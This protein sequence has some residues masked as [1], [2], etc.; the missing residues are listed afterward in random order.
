[1][2]LLKPLHKLTP[3]FLAILS[4]NEIYLK[5]LTLLSILSLLSAAIWVYGPHLAWGNFTP[6][7]QPEKR[8]YVIAC[9]FLIWVL[10][11]LIIDMDLPNP[12]QFKDSFIQK[13][14]LACQ[15]R[16]RGAMQF[17][18]KTTVSKNGKFVRLSQLPW[19]LLIGPAESGKTS[20]LAQSN[21]HFILQRQFPQTKPLIEPSEHC[22]WW[23]TRD[24]AIIDVPGKY[25][26]SI[27]VAPNGQK[28]ASY[29]VLWKFFLQLIKR[30]RGKQGIN[31]LIIALPLPELM[32]EADPKKYQLLIDSFFQR[33]N[34][35]HQLFPHH[36]PF[37]LLI[38]KCDL[39]TGFNE[40]FSELGTDEAA[41]A[42][43]ITL[44]DVAGSE[45]MYQAFTQRFNILIK[46]LNEQL[47]MRLH[48]ERNAA[49]R[50][51][52]KDFP[53]EVERLKESSLE[54]IKKLIA[55]CKGLQLQGVYLSSSTQLQPESQETA[56]ISPSQAMQGNIQLF[57]APELINR[58]YFIKQFLT[59]SLSGLKMDDSR[60][61]WKRRAAYVTSASA[62]ALTAIML[63]RDFQQ[64]IKHVY[65]IQHYITEYQLAAQQFQT[66]EER[67]TRTLA[68][69]D[70]LHQSSKQPEFKLDLSHFLSFYS[71]KSQETTNLIYLQT[72]Q[73]IL[74]PEIKSY[75]EEYLRVPINK[76]TDSI[77]TALKAYLMLGDPN[78]F[79]ARFVTNTVRSILPKTINDE[80]ANHLSRHLM[81]A[82]NTKQKPQALNPE[83]IKKTREFLMTTPSLSLSYM[84]LKNINN[85]NIESG[86]NLGVNNQN[87]VFI[88]LQNM[89]D[90]P[91][92]FTAKGF[93]SIFSQELA[94]AAQESIRGNWVL[95]LLNQSENNPAAIQTL[96][97]Q[98]RTAYVN[99][100]VDVWET[101]LANIQLTPAADLEKL[102]ATIIQIIGNTSPLL[103]LLQ[104]LRNNTFFQPIAA[105]SPRLQTLCV[106]L[107]KNKQSQQQ[108][109]QIFAGLN[110]LHQQLRSV[111]TASNPRKAAFDIVSKRM[112][113]TSPDAI[114]QLRLIAE[115]N[116]EP[117]KN[118]LNKIA[119]D[120]WHL[121]TEEAGN[122]LNTA[123]QTDVLRFYQADIANRYPFTSSNPQDVDLKKFTA[124]FGNPGVMVGFYNQYLHFL[125]DTSHPDWHWK[126][127][128]NDKFPLSN[129]TLHQIQQAMRIHHT[130]FPNG[131]NKLYMQFALEPHQF[132]KNVKS[133]KLMVSD[134]QII[135]EKTKVDAPHVFTWPGKNNIGTSV[136]FTLFDQKVIDRQFPGEWGW[137]KLVSQSFESAVTKKQLLIN[138]S[139]NEVPVK[140]YVFTEG[141]ANPFL[142]IDL[143]RFHLPEKMTEK[144]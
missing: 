120:T 49:A 41:Q 42:W 68:L 34:E 12:F 70:N 84:I 62:I 23:I 105:A 85:N 9:I 136:Q 22:D 8:G 16:F 47:L 48:Q 102:D 38:T 83:L 72:L 113:N 100:Y 74:V 19:Y 37:H 39:L 54:F 29:P 137:F 46:K 60:F 6:L 98:L 97:E 130:F 104:T 69:L 142:T 79:Q 57:Q 71:Y 17:L 80:A 63:G 86:V 139:Q 99:N 111:T 20:L 90:I 92:M 127:V 101:S 103:Q 11:F 81:L 140:Y 4:R 73:T 30:Q 78:H 2:N 56:L 115:K 13:K 91:I 75:L 95:G 44:S 87:S 14:L 121:L 64:G 32:K 114:M 18:K 108:L 132:G 133:V 51:H 40:Y 89:Q 50:P 131:D 61:I 58:P 128:G 122:Y 144:G 27:N 109:Y 43:G 31:G 33:I 1:M 141:T 112:Q 94:T 96:F 125:I 52:I 65:A 66:Q 26:S 88:S 124:F 53:L 129:E 36:I 106:L 135:D 123:W 24:A 25:L 67:L 35:L 28:P 119:D 107:D 21:V 126:S 116:P 138:L 118:W 134:K 10:E 15:N 76:N 7:A 93:P 117:I 82:F 5:T 45:K 3:N 55:Q 77:Y 59:H 110:Q 143:K